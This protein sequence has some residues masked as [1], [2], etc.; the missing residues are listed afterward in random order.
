VKSRPLILHIGGTDPSG[1][2]GLAADLKSTAALGGHGCIAVTAVTVQNSGRVESWFPVPAEAITRQLKITC[3]DG[4]PDAV[5]SGM[6]GSCEAVEAVSAVLQKEMSGVPYILDPVMV[7]GSGDELARGGLEKHIAKHLLPRAT[8]VTPNL[9]EA[10]AFTGKTVRTMQQMEEAASE[11]MDM[12]ASG[13]LLKGGHLNG[14]PSDFLLLPHM[15][16][17]FPGKRIV[18]GKVHGTGCTL[19]SSCATLIAAGYSTEKS[20]EKALQYL[21]A[22]ISGSWARE[23]GTLLGHFPP[24][25]PV[26]EVHDGSSFYRTPRFCPA[27]GGQLADKLPHPLCTRCGLVFYRNPLPAVILILRDSKGKILRLQKESWVFQEDLLI[28]EN[29]LKKLLFVS[30]WRKLL[31]TEL[32]R[33]SQPQTETLQIMAAWCCSSI[34]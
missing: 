13:V 30:S 12:G 21:R 9:D 2:A 1:G 11:I 20:V 31:F 27:C 15:Q 17:W 16:K 5:K 25:G 23:K 8:L 3:E 6:L 32:S 22:A 28:R 14:E 29:P 19:A 10:E 34:R 24:M 26:P 4:L 33:Y 7:A 18:P